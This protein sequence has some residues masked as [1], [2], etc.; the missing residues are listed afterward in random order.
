[1]EI[2]NLSYL[3]ASSFGS[4]A[5]L[6]DKIK[7]Y[8]PGYRILS[9]P[10]GTYRRIALSLGL[11][12][13]AGGLELVKEMREKLREPFEPFPLE[14]KQGPILEN[15]HQG[16]DVDL[17]R[18]P[19]PQWQPLDEGRAL[20]RKHYYY[21]EIRMRWINFGCQRV[22]IHDKST[23]RRQSELDMGP[24][25]EINIGPRQRVSVAVTCRRSVSC[26]WRAP[27]CENLRMI[28]WAG[29]GRN[30]WRLLRSYDWPAHTTCAE[31]V[32]E[33]EMVP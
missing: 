12:L 32:L 27:G 28:M 24:S 18:F 16:D 17:L 2:G 6:F 4:P 23:T 5:L 9:T 29:G 21:K 25:L 31:I 7:N 14:V 8:K 19:T 33:G 10:Y 22:Q 1:L 30:L 13:E 15:V 20:N 3:A 11:S 26:F